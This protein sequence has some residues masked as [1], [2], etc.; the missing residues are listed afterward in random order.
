VQKTVVMAESSDIYHDY[1][2]Q[3]EAASLA[4]DGWKVAVFGFR[5]G[6]RRP[7]RSPGAFALTTLPL[8]PRTRR[9]LR[10]LSI[11][12]NAALIN[13]RLLVVGARVYHAHNTMFL[14]GMWLGARLHRGRFVYDAHEVQ[15]EHGRLL[16]WLERQFIHRADACINVARGR[17]RAQAERYGLAADAI[18]IIANYPVLDPGAP[19]PIS[20]A[21]GG[22]IRLVYSGGYDLASNRLDLLARAMQRVPAIELHLVAFGYRDSEQVLRRLVGELGLTERVHFH[23]LVRPDEVMATVASY[24]VA[25]NMLTNP[26][27]HLSIRHCSVNKMYEYLAA[28]RPI[29]CSDLESFVEEFVTGGAAFAVDATDVDDIARGLRQLVAERERLAA[30]GAR[31]WD[32]ARTRYNWAS[33]EARLLELYAGLAAGGG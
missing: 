13:L 22:P 19:P 20:V 9:R 33:Q 15:W 2:V 26:G 1:R 23:P 21:A 29:L 10:N 18:T 6:R 4:A 8:F 31:A 3:K 24:D 5:N 28:G 30:M 17:A 25:V 12:V 27:G 11:V 16:A 14:W 7:D 32:L